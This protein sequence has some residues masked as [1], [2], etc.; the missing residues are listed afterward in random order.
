M[1][2]KKPATESFN[3]LELANKNIKDI[4]ISAAGFGVMLLILCHY[5]WI[6]RQLILYRDLSY[7]RL[8]VYFTA[9]AATVIGSIT[10]LIKVVYPN[11]YAEE[12]K[13][14]KLEKEK[15]TE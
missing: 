14:E 1:S 3:F 13:L 4:K 6:M 15:K 11:V 7:L 10:V 2:S 5:A 9:L 8:G 12:L